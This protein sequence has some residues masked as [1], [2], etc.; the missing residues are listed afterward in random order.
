MPS[1][2]QTAPQRGRRGRAAGALLL[3]LLTVAPP[4]LA[5][6]RCPSPDDQSLFEV[7]ALKTELMVAAV[8]CRQEERYNSFVQRFQP[9]LAAA[10]RSLTGWF[11]RRYGRGGA[12][13]YD[14][15]ITSLANGRSQFAHSIGSDF[16]PR[17]LSHF[18][19]VMSLPSGAELAAFAAGKDLIP[20]NLGACASG[21]GGATAAA[22]S[23][24]RAAPARSTAPAHRR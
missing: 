5:A 16:C 17:N 18:N 13:A 20:E 9:Q 19:E 3:A 2:T 21:G 22:S 23:R 11:D 4:A 14:D 7:A 10:D 1:T 6:T 24:G 12:R 15:F 8:A